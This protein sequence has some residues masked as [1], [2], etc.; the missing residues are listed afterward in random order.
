MCGNV[1]EMQ[2]HAD[3]SSFFIYELRVLCLH[4]F[5]IFFQIFFLVIFQDNVFLRL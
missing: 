3:E 4:R 5:W 2:V 1:S